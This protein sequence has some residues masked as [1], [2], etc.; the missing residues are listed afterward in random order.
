MASLFMRFPGGKA[1]AF[2]MSY[3]DGV[4][5]DIRLMEIMNK[6]GLKGTFN[7][8]AGLFAPEGTV[9][10]KGQIHRRMTQQQIESLFKGSGQEVAIHGLF[11]PFLE[12]LPPGRAEW[13]IVEDRRRLEE[14]FGGTVRGMAYPF[15]T[16]SSDVVQMVKNAGIVYARTTVSTEGFG[17]SEDWLRLPATCHHNNPRLMELGEKFMK[18]QSQSSP[19][20][21]YLW[22]HSY[23]FEQNDNWN[24]IENF[25]EQ[26]SGQSDIWY[27][28]NIEI[29][30]YIL[31][32]RQLRFNVNMTLVENPTNT[33]L[34]FA[35]QNKDYMV[36]A[37]KTLMID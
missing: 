37:G 20:M 12:Q 13:E 16:T 1:K 27:A 24:V 33:D 9:Y 35:W 2:T 26:I 7:I 29:F 11:H 32:Y 22:G 15:G 34:Y 23:E 18:A 31:A 19:M 25:A 5:Q 36:P 8:N 3:D 4:E 30:D 14:I 28:T 17:I 21:F 10:P 6:N